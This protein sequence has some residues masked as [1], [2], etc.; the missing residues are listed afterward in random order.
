MPTSVTA[1]EFAV[2][3]AD[4]SKLDRDQSGVLNGDELRALA[5]QQLGR[6]CNDNE[7]GAF[8]KSFDLNNDGKVD[9]GEYLTAI[10]GQGWTVS[11][12]GSVVT[13]NVY[14][15]TNMGALGVVNTFTADT[16]EAGGAFHGAIESYNSREWSF[17]MTNQGTGV[18]GSPARGDTMHSFK[19]S[20]LLGVTSFS[21]AQ[22][23]AAI[24][25][26]SLEWQ[27]TDYNL[28]N[29]NCCSFS[30]AFA[31]K[32]GVGPIPK[33]VN[34]FAG[35]GDSIVQAG[36]SGA[37]KAADMAGNLFGAAKSLF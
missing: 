4:F 27:G 33:W 32:L 8:V 3:K 28:L 30:D 11:G 23:A 35:I 19:E 25:Q 31:Q 1:A 7:F 37:D 34:R 12:T 10:L 20:I 22:V 36:A 14:N 6:A 26:M 16:I 29:R 2:Y 21:E 24:E 17:G 13:L 9:L 18:Y 15:V 5:E